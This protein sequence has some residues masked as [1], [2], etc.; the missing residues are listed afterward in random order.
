MAQQKGIIKIKGTIGGMTFYKSGDGYLVKEKS[1]VPKDKIMN[2]PAFVRTR[3]HISEFSRATKA[4]KMLRV[5][6]RNLSMQAKDR[7]L[8]SRLATKMLRVVQADATSIRGQRNV[9][10]GETEMLTG[11]DFNANSKLS[12]LFFPQYTTNIDRA[13]GAATINIE[14]YIPQNQI[15]APS[16]ATHFQITSAAT[17]INFEGQEHT[18][19]EFRSE[20]LPLN[21][22]EAP[23]LA[24]AHALPPAS[25]N[26][27]FL[28]LGVEFFI[29]TN[30]VNYPL[31]NGSF[32][33]LSIVQVD[34]GV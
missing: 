19:T 8:V 34:S 9:L 3:E 5:A 2:D 21:S 14:S 25:T 17:D 28:L 18:T 23:A 7:F 10:D 27:L 20:V 32:N 22:L 33:A 6:V 29:N 24:I 31:K 11:F 16:E 30:N 1:E 13:T 12:T 4:G 26:P 15:I